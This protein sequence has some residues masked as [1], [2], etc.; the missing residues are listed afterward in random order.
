M[1]ANFSLMPMPELQFFDNNGKPLSG[2]QVYTYQP[3]TTRSNATLVNSYTDS[4]GNTANP[5]PVVLDSA[6]RAKIWINGYVKVDVLDANSVVV[7][8]G[9]DNVSLQPSTANATGSQWLTNTFVVTYISAT[10]FSVPTDLTSTFQVGRRIQ[11]VVSAGTITGTISARSTGGS[12]TITTVTV[13]WD[14]TQL[15]SGLSSVTLGILTPT[16]PSFP[17][18]AT[19][20]QT[21]NYNMAGSDINRT[22]EFSNANALTFTPLGANAVPAGTTVPIMNIGAGLLTIA[23]NVS[24]VANQVLPQFGGTIIISDGTNWNNAVA[25]L[26]R[27]AT[28]QTANY[29]MLPSDINSVVEFKA[30]PSNL[31]CTVSN[32][33]V[34]LVT[35]TGHGC[36]IGDQIIFTLGANGV[37]PANTS[38]NTFYYPLTANFTAN[39]FNYSAS[40]GGAA[41]N[42]TSA[43]ASANVFISKCVNFTVLTA[44]LAPS[45]SNITAR[46]FSL[47]PVTV[48]G[49]VDSLAN[50]TVYQNAQSIMWSD[51]ANWYRTRSQVDMTNEFSNI[52]ANASNVSI[53]LGQV[54]NG[55]R[56]DVTASVNMGFTTAPSNAD[57]VINQI[58]GTANVIFM[59]TGATIHFP[60]ETTP[61]GT[62]YGLGRAVCQVTSNGTL[63]LNAGVSTSNGANLTPTCQIYGFFL[64]KQ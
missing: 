43:N 45:G 15:D 19:N 8:S 20:I 33:T 21:A 16:A 17:I 34:G 27:P 13:V 49:T 5:N 53:N 29:T 62:V 25:A 56:I 59:A 14:S 7:Y 40:N 51:A 46:N 3:G 58:A 39:A 26:S 47:G 28:V 54:T 38:L 9:I 35:A 11:A 22:I 48:V 36:N 23:G 63:T 55:D 6:G 42:T 37:M 12:P 61:V 10:Q 44:N 2:G 30:V 18:L 60:V 32:A 64:K 4:T 31:A 57:G 41:I 1:A 50:A 52:A 24:N